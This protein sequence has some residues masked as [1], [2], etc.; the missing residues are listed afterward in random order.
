MASN[1][2]GSLTIESIGT[3]SMPAIFLPRSQARSVFGALDQQH[4]N[5]TC[6]FRFLDEKIFRALPAKTGYTC[7]Q[8]IAFL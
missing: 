5:L 3:V 7:A 4:E 8:V 6:D 1:M 2:F